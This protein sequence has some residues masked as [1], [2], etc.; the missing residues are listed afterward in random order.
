[1]RRTGRWKAGFAALLLGAPGQGAAAPLAAPA[2]TLPEPPVEA[3]AVRALLVG[4]SDYGWDPVW[5]D[6]HGARDVVL[7]TQALQSLG[8]DP[9]SITTRV[10]AEATR[11]AV[12]GAFAGLLA[13]ARPGEHVIVAFSAHGQQ[14][15][16]R[17]GDEGDGW[18]EALA[19]YGAPAV[20]PAGYT[21][22]RH[23]L[24]DDLASWLGGLRRAVGPNGSVVLV[25][26]A[27][28]AA[29]VTRGALPTRGGAPPLG[30]PGP[31]NN[32]RALGTGGL[33]DTS[34]EGTG[35][36]PLVVLG[37]ARSGSV[38]HETWDSAG[39]PA[40]ALTW[41]LADTLVSRPELRVWED[42]AGVAA[43]RV[44]ARFP[45]Q[46][47]QVEAPPDLAV[48]SKVRVPP[49]ASVPLL[50][51]PSPDRVV[52]AGGRLVGL[53]VGA[54]VVVVPP[55]V[56]R[57]VGTPGTVVAADAVRATVRLTAPWVEPE[58]AR[59]IV[60]EPKFSWGALPVWVETS[61]R[62]TLGAGLGA[63]PF[64]RTVADPASAAV[65]VVGAPA[66]DGALAI[67]WAQG[68]EPAEAPVLVGDGPATLA[69][70]GALGRSAWLRQNTMAD[71]AFRF[72][73]EVVHADPAPGGCRISGGAHPWARGSVDI[74]LP[75]GQRAGH[76][77][78]VV[79]HRGGVPGF[80]TVVGVDAQGWTCQLFPAV[81]EV[82]P[83]LSPGDS[84]TVCLTP[85]VSDG[86]EAWEGEL[87]VF[88]TV[89]PLDLAPVVGRF[90][91]C[92][93][94][95]VRGA[96]GAAPVGHT[97]VVPVRVRAGSGP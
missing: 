6:L 74:K 60:V 97:V 5:K 49:Q 54:R 57:P 35:L 53:D 85:D 20:A 12:A 75:A 16:D 80:P 91:A 21:G 45:D 73:A 78:L 90:P 55:G 92:G 22:E 87:F 13:A 83:R 51:R 63:D 34:A 19:L 11:E 84:A 95:V 65:V 9:R 15:A 3:G 72:E 70:L 88:Q 4:L 94:P 1:V 33:W 48:F 40:G 36:A 50:A 68:P 42:V 59:A 18:D 61:A 89:E 62:A 64:L 29:G 77:A 30:A 26:D 66:P 56:R 10:D 25:I 86:T 71:A 39:V 76:A 67:R 58:G 7:M 79:T 27:C 37:A 38:A 46:H 44:R 81:G 41:A 28:H 52:V 32:A 69:R 24:D 2:K 23:L 82:A 14:V 17:D 93:A 47:P 96:P 8:V 43:D 31:A